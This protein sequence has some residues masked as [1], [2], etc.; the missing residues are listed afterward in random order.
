[1]TKDELKEAQDRVFAEID[2]K[3][4]H[5]S[6][7]IKDEKSNGVSPLGAAIHELTRVKILA[8]EE[9][10]RVAA[11]VREQEDSVR[12]TLLV[13]QNFSDRSPEVARDSARS[14]APVANL[15]I[16]IVDEQVAGPAVKSP[17]AQRA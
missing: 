3:L 5:L 6:E 14:L 10:A 12:H 2:S 16:G 7:R 8:A 9:T 17:S 4:P 13:G 1:M 15:L 11:M